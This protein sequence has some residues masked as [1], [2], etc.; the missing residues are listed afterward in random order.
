VASVL[1][2]NGWSPLR[3]AAA[4]YA[5]TMSESG[6]PTVAARYHWPGIRTTESLRPV[7]ICRNVKRGSFADAAAGA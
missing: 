2:S 1:G 6:K 5:S 3:M 4:R 7:T